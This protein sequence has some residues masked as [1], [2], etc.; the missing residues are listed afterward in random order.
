MRSDI[1]STN[2]KEAGAELAGHRCGG[3]WF[4]KALEM[5]ESYFKME[6]LRENMGPGLVFISG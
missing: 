4:Q 5:T 3:L 1:R 2:A 6:D